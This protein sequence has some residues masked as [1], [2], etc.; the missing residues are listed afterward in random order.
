MITNV[1]LEK[2]EMVLFF[3]PILFK[4]DPGPGNRSIT[5]KTQQGKWSY[6]LTEQ[7]GN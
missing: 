3:W 5:P 4:T 7:S 2:S 1:L 6:N